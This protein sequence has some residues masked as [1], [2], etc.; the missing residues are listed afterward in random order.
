V[1]ESQVKS[2]VFKGKSQVSHKSQKQTLESDSSLES[3][4]RIPNSVR[5]AHV[6]G[7]GAPN[8]V[9]AKITKEIVCSMLYELLNREILYI[10]T[11]FFSKCTNCDITD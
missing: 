7:P 6:I 8:N 1:L 11:C 2:Q 9:T 4:T 5:G 3:L 10:C